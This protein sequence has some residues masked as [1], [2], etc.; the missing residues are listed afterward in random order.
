MAGKTL[1]FNCTV[2][3]IRTE[4]HY[5]CEYKPDTLAAMGP[6]AIITVYAKSCRQLANGSLV[7]RGRTHMLWHPTKILNSFL[8]VV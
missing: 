2:K 5:M 8:V 6:D 3:N 4:K 7:Q 1:H